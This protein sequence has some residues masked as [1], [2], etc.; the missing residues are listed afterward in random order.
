MA[1]RRL[2]V[3]FSGRVALGSRPADIVCTE[4]ESLKALLQ[5]VEAL[6]PGRLLALALACITIVSTA[7]AGRK[8]RATAAEDN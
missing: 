4:I 3:T 2:L 1:C 8:R 7:A 6:T 5:K